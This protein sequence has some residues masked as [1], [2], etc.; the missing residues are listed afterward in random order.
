MGLISCQI[1][2]LVI[3]SRAKINILSESEQITSTTNKYSISIFNRIISLT[4][5]VITGVEDHVITGYRRVF[6][7]S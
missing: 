5:H 7:I 3:N 4:A 1:M 6:I 2:P